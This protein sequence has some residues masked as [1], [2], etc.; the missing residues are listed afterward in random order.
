MSKESS[1]IHI[2]VIGCGQWGPNHIRNFGHLAGSRTLMC[3][4]LSEK[5]LKAMKET[6]R[7][8]HPT[9]NYREILE[10]PQIHGVVIATPTATH[11]K[12][13]KEALLAGKDVL[14]EKP[15]CTTEEEAQEL[16]DL[17]EKKKRI[18][19]V[20]HVFLYNAG[21]RRLYDLVKDGSFG[22]LYYLHSE[23]TNLGPFRTDVS[24]V[25]DL[26][27]HDI[28]IFNYL[29]G[30]LPMEVSAR[31][32]RYLQKKL[33]DVAFISLIYPKGVLVNIHVSWL[34]PRKV[35][36]ITVVGEKQMVIYDDLDNVGPIKIYDR[37]VIPQFY[38]SFGEFNLLVKEG[39]I[40][41]PKIDM[42]EPLKT[43]DAH[44]LE[45]I[46]TRKQPLSD[47][48]NGLEVIRVLTAITESLKKNGAPVR[49]P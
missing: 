25:W 4:D 41:I 21:I 1:M 33:E 11:F 9:T 38:E 17:A 12:F 2:G 10:H 6:F 26:A 43:Q 20:G 13:V 5:R 36:Q 39:S 34:D 3:A 44:F 16:I 46:R 37:S 15:L 22:S 47:G 24:S 14:C 42:S 8:I 27:P 35:R 32:G 30:G 48:E 31:G 29:L 28:A 45:C 40:T 23:R 19:M 18:L 7:N 49:I